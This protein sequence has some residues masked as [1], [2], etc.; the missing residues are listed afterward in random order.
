[1][2]SEKVGNGP[3]LSFR[4]KRT[5]VVRWPESRKYKHFWTPAFSGVTVLM[6]FYEPIKEVENQNGK[7]D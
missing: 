3:F 5:N 1:M 4:R 2:N 7:N 6:T